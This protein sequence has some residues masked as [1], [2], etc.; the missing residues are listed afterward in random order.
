MSADKDDGDPNTWDPQ[1]DAVIVAP[2]NHVVLHE[3]AFIR[4]LSVRIPAGETERPHHHRF[5]S[6]MVIDRGVK[7][8]DFDGATHQEIKRSLPDQ[9]ETLLPI[10][11]RLPPQ[12]LHYIESLDTKAFHGIRIEFK[13]GFPTE[14]GSTAGPSYG[15][16]EEPAR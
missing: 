5:P 2:Q 11:R 3:D 12:A 4:V 13:K 8:R 9:G 1:L 14:R 16:P 6:V 15:Y 10:V 7:V